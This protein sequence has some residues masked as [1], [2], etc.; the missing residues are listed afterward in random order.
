MLSAPTD[1][2][3]RILI[4]GESGSGKSSAWVSIAD[5]VAKTR[6]PAVLHVLDTDHAW[7]AMSDPSFKERV[8]AHNVDV[9]DFKTWTPLLRDIRKEL[10]PDDWLIVDMIDKAWTGAQSWF[11]ESVSGESDLGNVYLRSR[12][13]DNVDIGGAYGANWGDINR[14][15]DSFMSMLISAPCHILAV[16][17]ADLIYVDKRSGLPANA[18]DTDIIRFKYKPAG[19]KRLRHAFHTVLLAREI[20]NIKGDS[21]W[22]LTTVKERGPI[23]KGKRVELKGEPVT[24][25]MG[26]VGAYLVKI[27]G[28][29]L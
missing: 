23:G 19:Q 27:A 28:W 1:R 5:F 14:L 8:V 17:P 11:W 22:N 21:E 9:G 4:Y 25:G 12:T 15:Y 24:A 7:E 2:R 26:F 16:T 3:E 13:D 20:C 6:S 29:K 18:N 10:K